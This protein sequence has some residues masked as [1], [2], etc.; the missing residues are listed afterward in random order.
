MEVKLLLSN[1]RR[2]TAWPRLRAWFTVVAELGTML[3]QEL[4]LGLVRHYFA[5]PQ[6][7]NINK[8]VE[9]P[10]TPPTTTSARTHWD[11]SPLP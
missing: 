9:A 5:F 10:G 7:L 4:A 1:G 2:G 3:G 11:K 8:R 6:W